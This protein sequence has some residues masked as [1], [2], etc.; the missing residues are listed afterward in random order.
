VGREEAGLCQHWVE[1][2]LPVD[3]GLNGKGVARVR[4]MA[5]L[6]KKSSRDVMQECDEEYDSSEGP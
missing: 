3:G 6:P 4:L 5:W 1:R 2:E